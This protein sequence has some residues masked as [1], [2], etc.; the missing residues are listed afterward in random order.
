MLRD[1]VFVVGERFYISISRK[2]FFLLLKSSHWVRILAEQRLF[3]HSEVAMINVRPDL[4]I[5][6]F[7][8]LVEGQHIKYK[9][10]S[11]KRM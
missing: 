3:V 8:N 1:K 11:I 10:Q 7:E 5:R 9:L 6:C 4:K 2:L